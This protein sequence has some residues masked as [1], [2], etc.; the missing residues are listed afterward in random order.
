MESKTK[1]YASLDILKT[2]AAVLTLFFH[3]NMHLGIHFGFFTP[4]ISQGAIAMDLF[5]MLSGYA[6]FVGYYA[7]EL[8]AK[9][10]LTF[11]KRRLVSIYPLYALVMVA[12]WLIPSYRSPLRSV[13][14]SLPVELSLMQSWFSGMFGFSHNGG[15]WFLSCLVFCYA[16]FPGLL[17]V[18]KRV[19]RA[20]RYILLLLCW[21]FCAL[22]PL[23]SIYLEMPN[24][25]SNPLLRM[26]EFFGGILLAAELCDRKILGRPTMWLVGVTICGGWDNRCCNKAVP[27]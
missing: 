20:S 1:Y 9:S 13:L 10:I 18:A 19:S 26:L 4:F 3:C 11:Y 27:D 21:L 6:L 23:M 7:K 15:T 25:Y 12:F 22:I 16:V 24:V 14:I 5:F 8:D 2:V 17:A